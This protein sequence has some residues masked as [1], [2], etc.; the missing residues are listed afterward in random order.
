[1]SEDQKSNAAA[2][3]VINVQKAE[4]DAPAAPAPDAKA[5]KKAKG[6]AFE[7]GIELGKDKGANQ[8]LKGLGVKKSERERVLEDLKAGRLELAQK[9]QELA[10]A[11]A[12]AEA[13]KAK[14]TK[15]TQTAE[16]LKPYQDRLKKYAD[17]EFAQLPEPYQKTLADM[18]IEDPMRR[19]D[20][21]EMWRKNGVLQAAAS[22]AE[23]KPAAPPKTSSTMANVT[24]PAPAPAGDKNHFEQWKA[25]KDSGQTV[26]AAQYYAAYSR[27][28]I[29][30][31]PTK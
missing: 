23:A 24:P 1:M 26:L 27:K 12:A 25:L 11:K 30:Q 9:K 17:Q 31:R 18:G 14:A 20:T 22:A 2:P 8:V 19:L 6:K 3:V 15:A 29:E 7:K 10:D 16:S 13:E 4:G 21:I 28:I 5:I